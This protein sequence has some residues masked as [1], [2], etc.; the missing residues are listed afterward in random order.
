MRFSPQF[1]FIVILTA[2]NA[3]GLAFSAGPD[4]DAVRQLLA[5]QITAWN[6]GDLTAF[7]ETYWK[8]P[9]LTFYSGG[10]IQKG[11]EAI[12]E[13][14]QRR[15]QADGNEMGRLQFADLQIDPLGPDRMLVRGRWKL[16]RKAEK[17]DGLFTLI[18]ARRPEGWRIVH[19][20]TS[21]SPPPATQP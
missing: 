6:R 9:E 20:H 3:A 16:E 13:R 2:L 11:W 8:S 1:I 5:D 21:A 12:R 10:E 15:Y 19:D 17:H 18:V 4:T 14:F 7:M